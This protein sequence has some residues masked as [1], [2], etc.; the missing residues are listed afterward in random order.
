M[1]RTSEDLV[2]VVPELKIKTITYDIA[3]CYSRHPEPD[4]YLVSIGKNTGKVGSV[5]LVVSCD[6]VP[7]RR[8]WDRPYNRYRL[9]V[10]SVPEKKPDVHVFKFG[11]DVFEVQVAGVIAWPIYWNSRSKKK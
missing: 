3:L 2:S 7:H 5:Y 8:D 11:S 1:K 4:E 10:I 9:Q 6:R